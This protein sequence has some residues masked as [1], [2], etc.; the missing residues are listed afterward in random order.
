MNL[1]AVSGHCTGCYKGP[2]LHVDINPAIVP[3][4]QRARSVACTLTTK[5][6]EAI[7]AN[8]GMDSCEPRQSLGLCYC[9][10]TY[11]SPTVDQ[12]LSELAGG[13][14]YG[15]IDLEEAYTQI[16]VDGVTSHM[17]TV[18][19]V[20]GLHSVARLPFGI[21]IAS[22]AFQRIIDGLLGPVKGVIAYQDNIYVKGTTVAEYRA[23]LLQVLHILGDAGFE[24]NSDKCVWQSA[25]IE[26][27][28]FMLDD[29]VIHPTTDKTA[30]ITNAPGPCTKQELQSS[31]GLISFYV[32]AHCNPDLPLV[33]TADT[34]PVGVGAMLAHIV[35]DAQPG[36]TRE[37][38]IAYASRT[39]SSTE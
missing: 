22:S 21:K 7:A 31:S 20:Q 19:T 27:L 4:Y 39:L 13:C 37:I 11:K 17:L 16:P 2:P 5:M 34:S 30:A 15:T 29:E 33:V 24:V 25:S 35:P 12:V 32:L 10:N 18:N 8:A 9:T 38:P 36:K 28:G 3:V 1:P 23:R 6:E 14:I 26:V